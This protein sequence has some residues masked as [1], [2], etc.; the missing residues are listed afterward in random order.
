M[1]QSLSQNNLE[2]VLARNETEQPHALQVDFLLNEFWNLWLSCP[3]R[4]RQ[5]TSK[6]LKKTLMKGEKLFIGLAYWMG[7]HDDNG[8]HF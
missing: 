6:Q 2:L 4:L 8:R 1:D 5:H 3:D 7:N